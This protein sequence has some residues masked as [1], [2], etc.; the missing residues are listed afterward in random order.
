VAARRKAAP[1]ATNQPLVRLTTETAR[2]RWLILSCVW[3]LIAWLAV[4]DSLAVRDYVALLDD[5]GVISADS[6]PLRRT[7]PSDYADAQ[8]WVRYALALDSTGA[9]RLRHTEIDNAPHGRPVHWSS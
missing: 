2:Q 3:A 4:L 5:S 9:W 6:L 1:D 8:T 7:V